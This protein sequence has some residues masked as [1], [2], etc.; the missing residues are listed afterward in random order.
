MANIL[1]SKRMVFTFTLLIL[2][3]CSSRVT[4]FSVPK[5]VEF[6]G[7]NYV[8]V[9][10]NQLDEMQHLLYLPEN[11]RK[12]AEDWDKGILFFFD[13]NSKSQSLE[14]RLAFR[15]SSFAKQPTAESEFAI[16]HNELQ[17][18]I[19][20]PPTERFQNVM[21]EVTRGRNLSCGYGQIQISDKRAINP[22][23]AK[24]SENLTAYTDEMVK[25]ALA[26]NQM[27]WQ[28]ECR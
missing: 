3:A 27:P 25:L 6:Q 15:Q 5:K 18:K 17:S 21:L 10:D 14:Q 9:T 4:Q 11:S 28:I 22:K 8:K 1:F 13:K 23:I 2:N 7:E 19:I 20:Y 12:N 26:F 24:K 16:L